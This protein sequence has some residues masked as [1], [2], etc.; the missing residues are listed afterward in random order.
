MNVKNKESNPKQFSRL[1]SLKKEL[2]FEAGI[3][4]LSYKKVGILGRLSLGISAQPEKDKC[5]EDIYTC[6]VNRW[7]VLCKCDWNN[8]V[9]MLHLLWCSENKEH[10][11][12]I[13]SE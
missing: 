8:K 11:I 10:E 4:L 5:K 9:Q 2:F 3:F 13:L 6:T 7:H 12:Q 1:F